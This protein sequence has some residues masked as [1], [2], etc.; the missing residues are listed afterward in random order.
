VQITGLDWV[1]NHDRSRFFLVLRLGRPENDEL[2]VLL[3]ACNAVARQ[4]GLATLYEDAEERHGRRKSDKSNA[5][6][7]SVAWTLELP[8]DQAQGQKLEGLEL[9]ELRGLEVRFD[10]V[11][12]KIGS[13]VMDVPFTK[14]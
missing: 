13:T 4:F 10:M 14:R 9:E 3:S 12:L 11:K 6:H 2:N 7:I 5:F 8:I 1:A